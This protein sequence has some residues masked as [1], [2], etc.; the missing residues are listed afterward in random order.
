MQKDD[1]REAFEALFRTFQPA[2]VRF[3]YAQLRSQE[4]SR[5]AVQEVFIK[6]WDKRGDLEFSSELK[7]YLYRSVRNNC[8]NRLKRLRMESLSEEN[9][10]LPAPEPEDA[11]NDEKATRIKAIFREID[12][13][14]DRAREIFLMSRVEGLSHKEIAVVLGLSP[15]TVENQ[16][17]IALKKIRKGV[18]KQK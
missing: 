6:I 3:A 4:E 2:L 18:F 15:K 5:E 10:D 17:G 13:L 16:V 14:P 12:Q 11:G 9:R 1:H 7:A 8:L